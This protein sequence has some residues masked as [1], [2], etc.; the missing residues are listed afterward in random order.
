[1]TVAELM[2]RQMEWSSLSLSLIP[3]NP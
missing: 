2:S 1:M 3:R